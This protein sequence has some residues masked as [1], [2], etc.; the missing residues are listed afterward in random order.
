MRGWPRVHAGGLLVAS[1][2]LVNEAPEGLVAGPLSAADGGQRAFFAAALHRGRNA[3]RFAIFCDGAA[4]NVDARVFQLG[5]DGV[6]GQ[7]VVRAFFVDQP[8]DAISHGLRRMRFA[9]FG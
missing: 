4:R 1:P 8:L 3:Q 5:H 6:V 9:A 2:V 7:D